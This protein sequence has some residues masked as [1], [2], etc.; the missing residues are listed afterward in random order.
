MTA[1]ER[2]KAYIEKT[3]RQD[4]RAYAMRFAECLALLNLED[5]F[6]IINTAF[7]Y[8]RAKGYREGKKEAGRP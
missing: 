3:G 2:M 8:G 6:E 5:K 7:N 4:K 1:I